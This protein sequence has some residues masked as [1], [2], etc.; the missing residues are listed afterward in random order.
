[1]TAFQN[2]VELKRLLCIN[3]IRCLSHK[4]VKQY[5]KNRKYLINNDKKHISLTSKHAY[6]YVT[7]KRLPSFF[8]FFFPPD[9][10][11]A[12]SFEAIQELEH[13]EDSLLKCFVN[14]ALYS[15]FYG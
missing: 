9:L 1:M 2:C 13:P 4:T 6:S 8:N 14:F 11:S 10:F 7:N 5:W 3:L 12:T 15:Y